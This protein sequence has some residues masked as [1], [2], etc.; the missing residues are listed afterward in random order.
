MDHRLVTLPGT[1]KPIARGFIAFL[2]GLEAIVGQNQ[3]QIGDLRQVHEKSE[4]PTYTFRGADEAKG[5]L[6]LQGHVGPFVQHFTISFTRETAL[7]IRD[8]LRRYIHN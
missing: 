8:Y 4:E 2:D 1:H 6:Y 3:V 5:A 7:T